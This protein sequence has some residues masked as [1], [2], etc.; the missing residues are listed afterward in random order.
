MTRRIT[1]DGVAVAAQGLRQMLVIEGRCHSDETVWRRRGRVPP[2]NI[3]DFA[4]KQQEIQAGD[5]E[6]VNPEARGCLGRRIIYDRE[7]PQGRHTHG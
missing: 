6:T 4:D 7:V 1:F 3:K 2:V 5:R